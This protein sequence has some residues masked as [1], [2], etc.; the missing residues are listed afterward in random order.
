MS[1]PNPRAMRSRYWLLLSILA[2]GISC[3]YT[4]RIAI[5][6]E[7]QEYIASGRVKV[8][9]GD[10]YSPWIGARDLL[11]F[12]RNPYGPQVTREI[13]MAFYGHAVTQAY[14]ARGPDPVDEQ[15]FAYPLFTVF[16]L[17]PIIYAPF[18]QVQIWAFIILAFLTAASVLLWL[19][20]LRWRP[21]NIIVLS[22][23]LLVLGSPQ[24][25]QGLRLRQLGLLAAF[26]MALSAW[27]I[28][29]H[30]L[31][32]AGIL[33]ALS[34]IKP[35]M[36]ILVAIWLLIWSLGNFSRRWHLAAGFTITMA[37]LSA[38]SQAILP[39]WLG[40]FFGA[41]VSYRK[42]VLKRSLLDAI[43]GNTTGDILAAALIV[44]LIAVAWRLRKQEADSPAFR[45]ML[46]SFLIATSLAMPLLP[47]FNQV[48][49]ILPVLI[50]LRD[51]KILPRWAQST[52]A[53]FAAWPWITALAL[54][55][56]GA[57]LLAHSR[58]SLLPSFAAPL[59]PFILPVLLVNRSRNFPVS[60]APSAG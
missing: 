57:H 54:L 31:T 47:P 14:G 15:R 18:A 10:L 39:S 55:P 13:Q 28:S 56:V 36:M 30:H 48:L 42:Y 59:F 12:G 37:A 41:L 51:W 45:L 50:L 27:C 5:P 9:M 11:L 34:A 21:P 43:L 19:R 16:L 29:R 32:S 35:Q 17:A 26:L 33:L 20:V 22:M 3:L 7:Y 2:A 46:S 24:L 44:V 60:Q 8:R 23:V 6:W 53:I 4:Y 38:A 1:F 25:V 40:D 58:I 49:L 52:F